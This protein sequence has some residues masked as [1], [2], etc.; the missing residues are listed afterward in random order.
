MVVSAGGRGSYHFSQVC[1]PRRSAWALGGSKTPQERPPIVA[2]IEPRQ[3]RADPPVILI[4]DLRGQRGERLERVTPPNV[5]LTAGLV[6]VAVVADE[7]QLVA[8]DPLTHRPN[9]DRAFGVGRF[10]RRGGGRAS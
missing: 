2:Q 3:A 1:G 8:Y 10:V 7:R 5:F 9:R 4:D 6:V